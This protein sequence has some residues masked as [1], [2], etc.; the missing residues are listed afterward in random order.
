MAEYTVRVTDH[1]YD[2]VFGLRAFVRLNGPAFRLNGA[3]A[4]R[5][6]Y[7]TLD[8]SGVGTVELVP[9]AEYQPFVKYT[10]G[11]EYANGRELDVLEF[12][13]QVGGGLIQAPANVAAPVGAIEIGSGI[14]EAARGV[15]RIDVKGNKDGLAELVVEKGALV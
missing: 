7:V 14:T 8:G 1:G 13:A 3:V 2:P 9:S 11:L 15:L 12:V 5:K 4:T 10:L 6:R